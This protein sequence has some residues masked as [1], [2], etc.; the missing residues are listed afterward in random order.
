MCIT[1]F[2]LNPDPS[3][4]FKLILV[5]NRDEFCGRP[6]SPACWQDGLLGGWDKQ[7]G[8]EGGTWLAAD[9]RGRVGLLTN[10]FTGGVLDKNAAGRGFIITDWLRSDLSAETYLTRLN[11]DQKLYNPFNLVLLE[12]D[13]D[14]QYQAWR[15]TRGKQGHTENYGPKMETSG[16]FGVSNHPQ[17][18]PYRKSV[19]GKEQLE[20]IVSMQKFGSSKQKLCESL[21]AIMLNKTAH[22][23]DEQILCQS[24]AGSDQPGPFAK[25]GENLSSV[26]VEISGAEYQTRTTTSILVDREDKVLFGEKNWEG[27]KKT[28][29][30]EFVIRN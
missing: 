30:E 3:S 25:F 9:R 12:Q 21:E 23:P 7:P 17:H 20:R 19:W 16:T 22:W 24:G 6:T 13:C 15:Y 5:M 2:H 11:N 1:F 28:S 14:G 18:Q 29:C 26:F 8:R 4:P 27:E 10:I